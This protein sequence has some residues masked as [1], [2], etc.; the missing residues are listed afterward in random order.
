MALIAMDGFD[1]YSTWSNMLQRRGVLQWTTS[2]YTNNSIVAGRNGIGKALSCA[3]YNNSPTAS[4][5]TAMTEG[6]VG[7]AMTGQS[8]VYF[9]DGIS[10]TTQC[11]ITFDGTYG[12]ITAANGSGAQIGQ[13]AVNAFNPSLFSFF[14]FHVAIG[15]AGTLEVRVDNAPVLSLTGVNTKNA[16]ASTFSAVKMGNGTVD[17]F[18]INDTTTGPGAYPNK[19]WLGDLRVVD[20]SAISNAS[21]AW[22]PLTGANWQQIAEALFDGDT[23]YNATTAVGAQDIFNFAALASTI[24]QIVGVQVMGA[25]RENDASTHTIAQ[26]LSIGGTDHVGTASQLAVTYAFL[27]DLYPVNPTTNASWTLADVNAILAGYQLAS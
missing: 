6:F 25:Y 19:S 10:G 18:R 12:K 23:S 21:V 13:S 9:I 7:M 2:G 15:S 5:S 20:L 3:T 27:A 26:H 1:N 22:T 14:E 4:L 16:S 24:D 8:A 11:S 17:D